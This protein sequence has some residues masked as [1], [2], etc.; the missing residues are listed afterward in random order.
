MNGTDRNL[1]AAEVGR[2][3]VERSS[4]WACPVCG[5]EEWHALGPE[6]GPD[7]ATLVM[8]MSLTQQEHGRPIS[9]RLPVVVF[10]CACCGFVRMHAAKLIKDGLTK[11]NKPN[12]GDAGESQQRYH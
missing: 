10:A 11:T 12:E 4:K 3:F 1:S 2:F 6:G 8:E 9:A 7:V 5:T